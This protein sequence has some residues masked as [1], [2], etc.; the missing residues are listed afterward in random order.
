MLEDEEVRSAWW[1]ERKTGTKSPKYEL[2]AP[3]QSRADLEVLVRIGQGLLFASVIM[4]SWG[5][6]AAGHEC[7]EMDQVV[8]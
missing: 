3:K 1:S 6:A 2:T 7:W 4:R 5:E 8:Q